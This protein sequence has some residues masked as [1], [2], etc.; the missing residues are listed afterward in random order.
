MIQIYTFGFF[1]YI[2]IH[3]YIYKIPKKNFYRTEKSLKKRIILCCEVY[4][5]TYRIHDCIKK[6][7][8][9]KIYRD[10]RMSI[11]KEHENIKKNIR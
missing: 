2:Q 3:I 5:Y 4:L 11:E 8:R 9:R 10:V 6:K 1:L 7:K